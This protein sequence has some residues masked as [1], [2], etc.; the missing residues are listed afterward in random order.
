MRK[1]CQEILL[2][3][4]DMDAVSGACFGLV[5]FPWPLSRHIAIL[6]DGEVVLKMRWIFGIFRSRCRFKFA[7]LRK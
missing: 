3:Q 4:L 1:G 5:C 2:V 7:R 6:F